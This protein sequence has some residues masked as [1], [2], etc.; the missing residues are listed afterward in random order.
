MNWEKMHFLTNSHLHRNSVTL[1]CPLPIQ[2]RQ[3]SFP[4]KESEV[5]RLHC[6]TEGY[7]E[8]QNLSTE[9]G[10]CQVLSLA[11][12]NFQILPVAFQVPKNISHENHQHL[13]PRYPQLWWCFCQLFLLQRIQCHWKTNAQDHNSCHF[14]GR[15]GIIKRRL[16]DAI[17]KIKLCIQIHLGS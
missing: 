8:E 14:W 12:P 2:I 4:I 16:W 10:L 5:W 9:R 13:L 6:L 1:L 3:H 7:L 15:Q 17:L 11:S